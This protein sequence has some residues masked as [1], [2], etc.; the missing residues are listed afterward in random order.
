[1][2]DPMLPLFV[3]ALPKFAEELRRILIAEERPELASQIPS[4]RIIDRCRCK[5]WFCATFKTGETGVDSID[6][7]V[8]LDQAESGMINVD[9]IDGRIVQV[10]VLWR[11]DVRSDLRRVLP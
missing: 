9:L 6:E 2:T 7:T 3:D 5:D 4:L 10:E 8:A 11:D 1:M